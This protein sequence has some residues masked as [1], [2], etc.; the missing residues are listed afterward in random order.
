[1]ALE[2]AHREQEGIEILDLKGRLKLGEEDLALR[3]EMSKAVA[4]GRIRFV[5]NLGNVSEVDS[6]GLETLV[7]TRASLRKAGGGLALAGRPPAHMNLLVM[8]KMATEFKV[9]SHEQEA[10][11]SF[12]PERQVPHVDI[13]EFIKSVRHESQRPCVASRPATSASSARI[14]EREF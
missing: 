10:V 11:N 14:L 2:I 5:V 12:F 3:N 1:M 8:E 9:F 7:C 6:T 13:L 4:A